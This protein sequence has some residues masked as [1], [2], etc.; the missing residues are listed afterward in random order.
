MQEGVPGNEANNYCIREYVYT[1]TLSI[2]IA[3]VVCTIH[4]HYI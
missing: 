1:S 4:V 2:G 3:M